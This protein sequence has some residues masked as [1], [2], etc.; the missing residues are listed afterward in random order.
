ME[1]ENATPQRIEPVSDQKKLLVGYLLLLISFT[2]FVITDFVDAEQ[3]ESSFSIFVGHYIIALGYLLYLYYCDEFGIMKSFRKISI[4]KTILLTNLF[5]ISAYSLNRDIPIFEDSVDWLCGYLIISSI[6]LL[7]YR[8]FPTNHLWLKRLQA[9]LLGCAIVL[10]I[11]MT[12]F[13]INYMPFGM[14]GIIALGIGAH[15]F[16]PLILVVCCVLLVRY[17]F[18]KADMYWLIAG[19]FSVMLYFGVEPASR[20]YHKIFKSICPQS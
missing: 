6:V 3:L 7:S 11:Y 16:V 1:T 5:L 12:L 20:G 4:D 9:F 10:Y 13:V 18:G 14:I 2:G 17:N 19:S 8:F 15:I